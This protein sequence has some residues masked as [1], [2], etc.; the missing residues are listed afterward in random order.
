MNKHKQTHIY[1]LIL[2]FLATLIKP[3]LANDRL[4]IITVAEWSDAMILESNGHYAMIDTGEDF[5]YPDGSDPRY[6]DREGITKDKKE[7]T[8]DRLFAH[9]KQL[10]IKKFDFIIITHAH[11][12]HVGSAHDVLKSIPTEKLYI[13]NIVMIEFLIKRDFGI[14]C[15]DMNELYRLP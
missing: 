7:I 15:M 3:V 8:Q 5:S 4:H 1:I 2:I 14:I 12:D 11:S 13:K 9:I 10:G 6:P